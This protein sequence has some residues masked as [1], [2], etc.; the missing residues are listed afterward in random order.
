MSFLTTPKIEKV[1]N[2]SQLAYLKNHINESASFKERKM[3]DLN[4]KK[5]IQSQGNKQITAGNSTSILSP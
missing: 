5:N 1:T 3:L 4:I 2:S